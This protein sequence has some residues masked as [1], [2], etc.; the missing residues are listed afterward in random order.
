MEVNLANKRITGYF[1][2]EHLQLLAGTP[3]SLSD[4]LIYFQIAVF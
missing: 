1:G 4:V 3:P 2:Q